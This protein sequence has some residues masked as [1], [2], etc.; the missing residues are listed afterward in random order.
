LFGR[1][2]IVSLNFENQ[3]IVRKVSIHFSSAAA[4]ECI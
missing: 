3:Q 2:Y 4:G 1:N